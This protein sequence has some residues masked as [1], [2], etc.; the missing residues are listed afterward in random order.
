MFRLRPRH[1]ADVNQYW[2]CDE[3]RLS[4]RRYQGEGRLLQPVV[5]DGDGWAV[6]TWE[7]A[8]RDVV[9]RL[10]EILGAHGAGAIAGIVSAQATNEELFLFERLVRETLQGRTAGVSWSPPDALARRLSHRRRQESEH[11][12]AARC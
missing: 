10:R 5:R 3:G 11:D 12:R 8:Q 2:M 4:Y 7:A 6:R 1:N 9:T